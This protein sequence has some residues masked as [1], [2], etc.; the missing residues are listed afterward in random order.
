AAAG[1]TS[2]A[3]LGAAA[4]L[5]VHHR[6]AAKVLTRQQQQK[7]RDE[8][9]RKEVVDKIESIY[10]ATKARVE[11]KLN[12]LDTEVN[13]LFD[14]G[15]DGAIATMTL[16][17][18]ERIDA[19]KSDRYRWNPFAWAKDKL[20]GLPDEANV[21][22]EEG[23]R[24]F[25]ARMDRLIVLVADVVELRLKQAKAE[26]TKGKDE[27]ETY[28]KSQPKELQH[29]AQ[30]AQTDVNARFQE[31][32]GSIEEKKNSLAQSL[33]QKYKE[34]FDKS[35]EAL[36]AIQEANKGLVT[37]FAE[38]LGEIIKALR[39]FKQ[40]VVAALKKSD[41]TI[42]RIISDPI[43]FLG[44][45]IDAVK[46]GISRF[47]DNIWVHLKAGFLEWLF[48]NLPP[49]VEIPTDVSIGSIFK[50]VLGVLGITYDRMRAKA[51]KLIGERNVKIIEKVV[52]YIKTLI[53][54]GIAALWE[55]VK[56]DLSNL[57]EMVFDALQDWLITTLIKKAVAKIVLLF[58]PV[59]AIIQAILGIIDIV[60]FVVENAKK[61]LAFVESVIN[62]IA[63]IA[64][65]MIDNAIKKV[66]DALARTIPLLISFLARFLGLSGITEKIR[67]FIFK[68]QDRV[69]KAIDKAIAKIVETMK[70]VLGGSAATDD[71]K[72]KKLDDALT[73]GQTAFDKFSG[74]PVGI[75]VLRPLL[76]AIRI[77][78]GLTRL[79]PVQDGTVWSIEGEI[80]PKGKRRTKAE[81]AAQ[82]DAEAQNV[83]VGN[84]VR[85]VGSRQL[86]GK[87]TKVHTDEA[88][89]RKVRLEWQTTHKGSATRIELR[90]DDYKKKWRYQN[91]EER[92]IEEEELKEHNKENK[93]TD[94]NVA[95]RVLNY[96]VH[97]NPKLQMNPSGKEWE[98]I[99]EKSR[100]GENSVKNLALIDAQINRD[101]GKDFGKPYRDY[102]V[103]GFLGTGD[104]SL[105]DF[106][107]GASEET[108]RK[109]KFK[110]YDWKYHVKLKP[111]ITN[112]IGRYQVID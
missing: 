66:E 73:A 90:V 109:W 35:N 78:Y 42:S 52:S 64:S 8:A 28:V 45:L 50:L 60:M 20:V 10:A 43:G 18:N 81:I 88:T 111:E 31:L 74:H 56:T 5:G 91:P 27:I 9:K 33:A 110:F 4:M 2:A 61:I 30:Q 87:V 36:K 48:G 97:Q 95:R 34:G 15:V 47:V 84:D 39:E 96:R 19:W 108:Y 53:T 79:E 17:V 57:K 103:P 98:H 94:M 85:L 26:V 107:R 32:E 102:E 51:V 75:A 70:K 14:V 40:R 12:D 69:D 46:G 11:T 16:Y 25:Q 59:G 63:D 89:K 100:G 24:V 41:D 62:S 7:A 104:Q 3:H 23:R 67:E 72:Q 68:V 44:N 49:G 54:G 76:A 101:L 99:H 92:N 112:D 82:N 29:V 21:F 80:N 71:E 58:N 37:K 13:R 77:R 1:A 83:A 22:Y 86:A 6:S 93:W 38:K 105:R 106:L 65:G 55:E